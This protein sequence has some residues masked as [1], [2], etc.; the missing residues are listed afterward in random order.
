MTLLGEGIKNKEQITSVGKETE[1]FIKGLREARRD[2][3]T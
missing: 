1:K 2:L 3:V